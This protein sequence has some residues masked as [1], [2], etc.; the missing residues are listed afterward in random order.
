MEGPMLEKLL[1]LTTA[2]LLGSALTL[3]VGYLVYR[4]IVL[5][6]IERKMEE[7]RRDLYDYRKDLGE[8][9][10]S[11]VRKGIVEGVT[12]LPSSDVLKD[13]GKSIGGT[14]VDILRGSL[15]LLL[16]PPQKEDDDQD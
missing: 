13:T 9:I 12:S 1:L 11:R 5:P 8:E 15:D 14:A 2:A 6:R 16:A 3:A 4:A 10:Q 7:A